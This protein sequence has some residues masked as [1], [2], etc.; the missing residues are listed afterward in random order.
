VRVVIRD[1]TVIDGTGREPLERHDVVI[2]AGR[3]ESLR[4]TGSPIAAD[5]EVDGSG[6]SLLP[7]LTDAHVHFGIQGHG[8]DLADNGSLTEYVLAIRE[9]VEQTLHEGFTTVRDAGGLDPVWGRLVAAGKVRGPRILPSGSFISQT[10]G[11]GDFRQAHEA[12][13]GRPTLAGLYAAS[14]IVDGPDA[15]RRAAREQLRRGATQVKLMVSG[16]VMSPTDPLDSIQ[17]GI[18]EI[19]AA[20]EVA[21]SWQ[22]YV[23]VH[24]HTSPA[25]ANALEAGVR[26]IEHGS[27]LDE[28]TARS[29][30]NHDAF[31]VP[32][33]LVLDPPKAWLDRWPKMTPAEQA[34]FDQ[35][36]GA[37]RTSLRLAS[38]V[39]VRLGSGSDLIG[40]DQRG[41]AA[42]IIEK[43]REL[44]PMAA[45]VSATRTNAELFGLSDRIGTV[46]AGKDA[47]LVLIRGSV[48]DRIDAVAEPE[49]IALVVQRGEIVRD[50]EAP[51]PV[52]T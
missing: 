32:T 49:A 34:K 6:S 25:I 7:G 50:A 38:D 20:V 51:A 48:L 5:R 27:I 33:T 43:A 24:A 45:L 17:F 12:A 30:V 22:T 44:G 29:I 11:H 8:A 28:R 19:R 9:T 14:E 1:T 31:M 36:A 26:S 42:E 18:D 10:G 52:P 3:I 39:G 23:L 46:E 40:S 41:R 4:P 47:D 21:R 16:G 13:H 35:I 37:S 15:V 2:D